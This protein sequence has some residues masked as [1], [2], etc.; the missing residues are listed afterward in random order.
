[1]A[2]AA[3]ESG[4]ATKSFDR[5]LHD[6]LKVAYEAFTLVAFMIAAG[7][8]EEIFKAIGNHRD[9]RIK[10]ALL[11]V[12]KVLKDER[13]FP[14]LELVSRA[15]TLSDDVAERIKDTLA[16]FEEVMA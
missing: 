8:T 6:D 16:S 14:S 10:F 12:L 11:H 5:L 1:M 9:E 3:I 15:G 4:F 13:T 2:R 7:E